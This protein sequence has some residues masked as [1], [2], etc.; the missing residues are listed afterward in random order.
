M[1]K[2]F[3]IVGRTASGKD[4]LAREIAKQ[5]GLN[6]LIS[7][8]TRPKRFPHEDTHIFVTEE[9]YQKDRNNN[10]I[11]AYTEINGNKY[12]CTQEQLM[13]S[14]I[15]IIDPHGLEVLKTNNSDIDFVTIYIYADE[16]KRRKRFCTR[17]PNG[18]VL[19]A[20]RNTSENEPCDSFANNQAYDY[21]VTND[22]FSQAAKELMEIITKEK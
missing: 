6:I 13:Q 8:T 9:S 14:D 5:S 2:L 18:S 11:I 4:T 12:W 16:D 21:I 17:E 7:Y 10:Q 15:Y 19:F 20:A 1:K 22:K 3:C